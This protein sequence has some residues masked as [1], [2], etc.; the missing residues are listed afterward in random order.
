MEFCEDFMKFVGAHAARR[1]GEMFS[2][3]AALLWKPCAIFLCRGLAACSDDCLDMGVVAPKA[4]G[5]G[6]GVVISELL[7]TTPLKE[8]RIC[9]PISTWLLAS[10]GGVGT[11]A[12]AIAA[13]AT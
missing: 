8:I 10:S 4:S 7:P 11:S 3:Y 1:G 2:E 13:P 6:T 12:L 5:I 9:R